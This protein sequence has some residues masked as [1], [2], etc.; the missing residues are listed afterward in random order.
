MTTDL[1]DPLTELLQSADWSVRLGPGAADEVVEGVHGRRVRRRRLAAATLLVA[2]LA[3]GGTAGVVWPTGPG[4]SGRNVD[5]SRPDWQ[6][7]PAP[8]VV[9]F[10][11]G[12]FTVAPPTRLP[13]IS[14]GRAIELACRPAVSPRC[15]A[16]RAWLVNLTERGGWRGSVPEFWH[17]DVWIVETQTDVRPGWGVY[18]QLDAGDGEYL[19]GLDLGWH[20][21]PPRV[22]PPIGSR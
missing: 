20:S 9:A 21:E 4:G 5:A 11:Q 14:E 3:A 18:Q 13:A 10:R 15:V 17:R 8:L 6:H 22:V 16:P 2:A 12:R 7:L 19:G 1:T